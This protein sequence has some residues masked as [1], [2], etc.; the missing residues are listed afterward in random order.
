MQ[1]NVTKLLVFSDSHGRAGKMSAVFS[2]HP[3][4]ELIIFLGDGLRDAVRVLC[5]CE[6]T[7]AAVCGNC[8][9]SG[10]IEA[11]KAIGAALPEIDRLPPMVVVQFVCAPLPVTEIVLLL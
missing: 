8:D 2:E 1:K 3:D 11:A 7:V 4:A 10:D 6:K 9:S 5:G